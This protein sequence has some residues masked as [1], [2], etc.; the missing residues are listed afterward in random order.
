M[1]IARST[2][3]GA[4]A[5]DRETDSD[6]DEPIIPNL[7]ADMA[8]DGPN[9]L[10]VA[11][12]TY[13]AIAT[14]FLYLA[15][16]LDAWS[17][18]SHHRGARRGGSLTGA[19]RGLRASQRPRFAIRGSRLPQAACRAQA[20]GLDGAAGEIPTT[21]PKR[22]A[23]CGPKRARCSPFGRTAPPKLRRVG[24]THIAVS[25]PASA[26]GPVFHQHERVALEK[27]SAALVPDPDPEIRLLIRNQVHHLDD[28]CCFSFSA[29]GCGVR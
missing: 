21:T 27:N 8:P 18:P 29:G 13:V 4:P 12:I 5:A 11:D 20:R 17:R 28:G 25:R 7:A 15:A 10:W 26:A 6:H 2:Y 14:G 23:S 22:R 24:L 1:G 9:Q 19:S 3:Y 16:I